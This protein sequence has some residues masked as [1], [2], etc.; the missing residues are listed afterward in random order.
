MS[1]GAIIIEGHV[2][3]LSNTRALGRAGIP[4]YVL[5]HGEKCVARYSRYCAKYFPCPPYDSDELAHF[6][7]DLA[8]HHDVQGWVVFPSN[9]HAVLTLSRN[10]KLLSPLY[11]LMAPEPETALQI[12]DK[13]LLMQ[14]AVAA[15]LPV[16]CTWNLTA[17]VPE[18]AVW[19][20]LIKGRLGLS[21]YRKTG[22]K[23][24]ICRSLKE[25][26]SQKEEF[27]AS[28]WEDLVMAQEMIPDE[29]D[30]CTISVGIYCVEGT[31]KASWT[32]IKVRQ[33]PARFGTATLARSIHD[34]EAVTYAENMMK[35]LQY[36]G[37]C[38]IEL[39]R[40][41][42]DGRLRLIEINPR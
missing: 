17:P 13:Y 9:D 22:K 24:V 1:K 35:A 19:P 26:Q 30:Q 39:L 41:P 28:G 27:T 36:N 38:E 21:F 15:G 40:D 2:Q 16:P 18:K 37:I 42:R 11:H 29:K 4:V 33:H 32:G 10:R 3:G 8:E 25:Y 31:I 14:K 23:V 20:V 5:N 12:C 6:L 34:Q 7:K